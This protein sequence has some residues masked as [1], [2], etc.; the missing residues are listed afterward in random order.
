MYL[1]VLPARFIRM[2]KWVDFWIVTK[3]TCMSFRNKL[4]K[5][6]TLVC[7]VEIRLNFLQNITMEVKLDILI[8]SSREKQG[9]FVTWC[10]FSLEMFLLAYIMWCFSNYYC[11]C[12]VVAFLFEVL[13]HWKCTNMCVLFLLKSLT[14]CLC[15]SCV[16]V[17][18]CV[19]IWMSWAAYMI[20]NANIRGRCLRWSYPFERILL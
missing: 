11:F 19:C 7:L 1:A 20:S 4:W 2:L 12:L 3:C 9:P 17:H 6:I 8:F 13:L 14:W 10:L 5:M 18:E 16:C 15:F